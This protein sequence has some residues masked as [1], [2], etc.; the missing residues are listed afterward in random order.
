[1]ETNSLCISL[2][3][4]SYHMTMIVSLAI[5]HHTSPDNTTN[6]R[7]PSIAKTDDVDDV[8]DD[9]DDG[10]E[11]DCHSQM[12]TILDDCLKPFEEQWVV[13]NQTM[14]NSN[15]WVSVMLQLCR[16]VM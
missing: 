2:L 16:Y 8:G 9:A 6:Y 7:Q 13:Y 5:Q 15:H 12:P 4:A 3:L 1:M 10:S 14:P 11:E